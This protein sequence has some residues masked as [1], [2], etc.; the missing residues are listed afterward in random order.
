MIRVIAQDIMV[1]SVYKVKESDTVRSVVE[2]FIEKRISGVPVVNDRNELVAYVSDGD[3]M[4]YIGKHKDMVV[5]SIFY[6]TVLKGDDIAFEERV[7]NILDL[8]VMA[9]ATRKVVSVN[10]DTEVEEI[11]A[12]LGNRR[13]KKVPVVK[14][15]VLVGVISRGDIIRRVFEKFL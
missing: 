11:A 7:R 5:G 10:W 6:F 12:I 8:N 13:Y 1:Q 3:I 2:R 9:I 14:N 15:G 4:R